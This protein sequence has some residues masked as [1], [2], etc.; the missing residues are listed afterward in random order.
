MPQTESSKTSPAEDR[1]I[2]AALVV[3]FLSLFALPASGL[4]TVYCA[5]KRLSEP[6]AEAHISSFRPKRNGHRGTT[7]YE[8][9]YTYK[10]GNMVYWKVEETTVKFASELGTVHYL[11]T[12]PEDGTVLAKQWLQ[13]GWSFFWA[14]L[15]LPGFVC[16]FIGAACL[17]VMIKRKPTQPAPKRARSRH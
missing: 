17:D 10:V 16:A 5:H 15:L 4:V 8:V 13:S 1:L 7:V 6:S 2:C 14:Q 9:S 3:G 11:R 12:N